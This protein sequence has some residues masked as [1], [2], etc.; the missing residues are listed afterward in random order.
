MK[1]ATSYYEVLITYVETHQFLHKQTVYITCLSKHCTFQRCFRICCHILE[2]VSP[3]CCCHA[4][5][6]SFNRPAI[7]ILDEYKF[8]GS[9]HVSSAPHL[10]SQQT[11]CLAHILT[12]HCR[13]SKCVIDDGCIS[14]G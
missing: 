12:F 2:V 13:E 3:C 11:F 4:G 5:N 1:L 8:S 14:F 9:I 10:G 7:V 6:E